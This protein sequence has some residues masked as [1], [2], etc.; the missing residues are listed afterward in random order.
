MAGH[1]ARA[2]APS[3]NSEDT[4]VTPSAT[5]QPAD[6]LGPRA[7]QTIARILDATRDVFLTRGYSGTTVDEIARIA[8]V[9]RA[10]FYTYFP[11]KRQV[12]L[13]LGA[14]SARQGSALI[15]TLSERPR[16]RAGMVGFVSD[17]FDFFDVHGS[18]SFAW[19]QAAQEDE[20][21]RVAGMKRHLVMCEQIGNL[22]AQSAGRTT[23]RP[24]LLGVTVLSLLERS[25]NY[26]QLYADIVDRDAVIGETARALFAIARAQP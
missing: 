24:V 20:E 21:I 15:A 17:F 2:D 10:S 3:V 8:D 7:H 14:T 25:W 11:S 22:L 23:D 6:G 4:V 13:S 19:T 12:L 26:G 1:S 18:F 5:R 16:T 9:S